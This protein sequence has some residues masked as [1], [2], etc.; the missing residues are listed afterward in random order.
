[1]NNLTHE[2]FGS[3]GEAIQFLVANIGDEVY[4]EMVVR[5]PDVDWEK[6]TD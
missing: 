5:Y 2:S 4:T 3:L 1:M 6:E